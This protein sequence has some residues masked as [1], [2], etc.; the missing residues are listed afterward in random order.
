MSF[1]SNN[2][3]KQTVQSGFNKDLI[4]SPGLGGLGGETGMYKK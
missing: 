1:Y 3:G 2:L 4:L